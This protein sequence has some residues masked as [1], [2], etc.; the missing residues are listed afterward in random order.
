MEITTSS[1][2]AALALE[3]ERTLGRGKPAPQ[4]S[5]RAM[6]LLDAKCTVPHPLA[7]AGGTAAVFSAPAPEKESPNE[8]AAMVVELTPNHAV[9]VVA[10]G[11]GGHASGEHAARLAMQSLRQ[12]LMPLE[13]DPRDTNADALRWAV[14][15]GI[16]EA[17]RVVLEL[18]NGAATTLAVVEV[19]GDTI[20]P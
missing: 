9:L 13:I 19:Q 4:T 6:S 14:L 8:D 20:R 16:E 15:A 3:P 11:L 5:A 18:G 2:G 7:V 17:N 12:T 10:D 1:A